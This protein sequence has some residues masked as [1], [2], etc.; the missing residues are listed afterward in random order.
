MRAAVRQALIQLEPDAEPHRATARF[1][2]AADQE[3]FAGHFPGNPLVPG[4]FL[5]EMARTVAEHLAG[6][7]LVLV[8]VIDARF[9]AQIGPEQEILAAVKLTEH[10]SLRA[11]WRCEASLSSGEASAGRIRLTLTTA[12]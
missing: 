2:F 6:V 3:I 9:T 4:V 5:I 7:R 1:C 10:A 11:H 12:D 8:E